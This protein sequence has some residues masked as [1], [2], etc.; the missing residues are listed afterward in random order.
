MNS[1]IVLYFVMFTTGFS[2]SLMYKNN[3][4]NEIVRIIKTMLVEGLIITKKA[5]FCSAS[6]GD[7]ARCSDY[8]PQVRGSRLFIT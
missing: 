7:R 3:S 2:I 5:K 6:S 1:P 4:K 8:V